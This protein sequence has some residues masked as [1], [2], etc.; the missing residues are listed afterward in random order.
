MLSL[1]VAAVAALLTACT[2]APDSASTS[3]TA[4]VTTGTDVP[5]FP[6]SKMWKPPAA[7]PAPAIVMLHGSE[8]GSAPYIEGL[9]QQIAKSGFVVVTMCWFGCPGKPD[10]IHDIPLESVVQIGQWLKASPDANGHV[11]LFGWSRGAELALLVSSLTNLDP[12]EAVAVHAPS[13]TIVAGFDPATA[14]QA[15]YYGAIPITNPATGQLVPA[16]A[17]T[18]QTKELFGEPT[19]SFDVAGP[20]IAVTDYKGPVYVSQGENDQV[21]PVT[22]GKHVVA[23]RQAV[24]GL[25]TQSH[26]YPGEGHIL[27]KPQDVL[28]MEQE[29]VSFF[30]SSLSPGRV[31]PGLK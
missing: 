23:E 30:Q 21:W 2:V 19:F 22:R 17:W 16:P 4:A 8:G 5:G 28:A 27:Q 25:V 18:W 12:F 26:F 13:D 14:N 15:P 20:L 3:T 1:R 24:P 11:G 31:Q 6:G 7:G 29:I 10:T 9:A